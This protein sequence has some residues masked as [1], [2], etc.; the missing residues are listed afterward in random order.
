MRELRGRIEQVLQD[1]REEAANEE[2][3]VT[4]I[5]TILAAGSVARAR[6]MA[7]IAQVVARYTAA[8]RSS[9]DERDFR[10]EIEDIADFDYES[11]YKQ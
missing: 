6:M 2:R 7:E 8:L 10:R 1:Y 11:T 3:F 5:L 4:E 9:A